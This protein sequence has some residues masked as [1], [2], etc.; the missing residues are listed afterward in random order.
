MARDHVCWIYR[1]DAELHEA[2]IAFLA[3]GLA[4]GE[5]LVVVGERA[6]EGLRGEV[7]AL[8]DVDALVLAG[9]LRTLTLTE[10]Y[11]AAGGFSAE[12]QREFY[13]AA[14]RQALADGY[15][16]LRVLADVSDLAGD[17]VH[18]DELVGWEHVA[19]HFMANGPGMSAMCTYRAD[20][21][22]AAL[23]DVAA[24]HPQVHGPAGTAPFRLFFDGRRL[25]L[26][27]EVDTVGAE[28]LTR[29][30]SASPTHAGAHALDM[31]ELQFA[32]VAACRVIAAW[33]RAV[34]EDGG[35]VQLWNAPALLRRTWRLL[36]LDE[37]AGVS[38][39]AAA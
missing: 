37:W 2:G 14:T 10:A 15:T 18:H 19:D 33:A 1:D 36:G 34:V 28:R 11:V 22:V 21:P 39:A 35:Q 25:V 8:G 5:R 27:G 24:V 12:G 29:A 13:D 16:G 26:A 3:G 23:A 30:L 17:P 6:I 38:F 4:R 31:A 7:P 20:L 32:D 9:T